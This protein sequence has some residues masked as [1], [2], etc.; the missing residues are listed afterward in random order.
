MSIT[1]PIR[2]RILTIVFLG[3]ITSGLSLVA[4]VR[5]LSTTATQRIERARDNVA[6]EAS[7]LSTAR[8]GER[9]KSLHVPPRS[10]TIGMRGGYVDGSGPRDGNAPEAWRATVGRAIREAAAGDNLVVLDAP[11]PEGTLVAGAR[12]ARD[13]SVAWAAS[14]VRSPPYLDHWRWVVLALSLVTL[15]LVAAAVHAVVTVKRSATALN[16]AMVALA[17]DLSTPVPRPPVRELHDVAEGIAALARNLAHSREERERLG[18]ELARQERLAA[19]GRVVAGVA[20]EVRNPLASIKL[21]LDLAAGASAVPPPVEQAVAHASAEITRLD[22]LVADLLVV[23]GRTLG[24][25]RPVALGALV[26]ERAEALGPWA[27]LRRVGVTVEGDATVELDPDSIAR[28]VDNLVRN[29]IEA[30]PA[31]GSVTVRVAGD[32]PTVRVQIDDR[33]PGVA[34]GRTAELFEPFFT[35]KADGTGLGLAIVHRVIDDHGGQVSFRSQPGQTVFTVQ[36]P[37]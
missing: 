7:F 16:A 12:R 36:L 15:V 18:R 31:G 3:V 34:G 9:E 33:G 21:R 28:A 27:Q 2:H 8:P 17:R 25:K 37:R 23:A 4:L 5:L 24:P 11:L 29:A 1:P 20:H 19:L 10:A 6:E 14:A 26:R 22:R 32:G 35:T 30:S 13:G